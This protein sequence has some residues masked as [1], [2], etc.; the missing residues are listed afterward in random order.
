MNEIKI[1][2]S[3]AFLNTNDTLLIQPFSV[4]PGASNLAAI[5]FELFLMNSKH[6]SK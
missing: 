6:F 3:S 5:A 2:I 1:Y 4:L